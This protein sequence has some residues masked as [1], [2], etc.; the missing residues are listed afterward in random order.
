MNRRY[1]PWLHV[2]A[3]FATILFLL[4]TGRWIARH[5]VG[6]VVQLAGLGLVMWAATQMGWRRLRVHAVVDQRTRLVT[7]GPYGLVRHPMYTASLLMTGPVVAQDFSWVRLAVWCLLVIGLLAKA[8]YE[9]E[10]L[11]EKFPEYDAY[12]QRTARL[13]PWV[14]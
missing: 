1:K 14:Y 5:P 9:E 4:L 6:L 2:A 10:L 7:D 8:R 3:Q 13:V 12:C 11:R